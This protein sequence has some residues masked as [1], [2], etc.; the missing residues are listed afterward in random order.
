M[1]SID[2]QSEQGSTVLS[3]EERLTI[4]KST[5]ETMSEDTRLRVLAT[6]DIS[7]LVDA[8]RNTEGGTFDSAL[9][10]YF[11]ANP[12]E[13]VIECL[14]LQAYRPSSRH[15]M[16]QA[17]EALG[18][19]HTPEVTDFLT[20]KLREKEIYDSRGG[21]FG[22][23]ELAINRALEI[24]KA[25]AKHEGEKVTD[26]LIYASKCDHTE[27]LQ[28]RNQGYQVREDGKC[29]SYARQNCVKLRICA[30]EELGR[31]QVKDEETEREI[32]QALYDAAVEAQAEIVESNEASFNQGVQ[33][34]P[35]YSA[36]SSSKKPDYGMLFDTIIKAL[37]KRRSPESIEY[38]K[39]IALNE[40]QEDAPFPGSPVLSKDFA[41][42]AAEILVEL[43]K[44]R[45][46]EFLKGAL[47]ALIEN[48]NNN[49]IVLLGDQK[50][51][52]KCLDFL[53]ELIGCGDEN[54]RK[55]CIRRLKATEQGKLKLAGLL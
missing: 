10:E 25:T 51:S 38:L 15:R 27:H 13:D 3:D 16:K 48:G 46:D 54:I 45:D 34:Y 23:P 5:I 7:L 14:A 1:D 53:V 2:T 19:I 30:C 50:H 42:Q 40:P 18:Q 17:C 9:I 24:C 20:R 35:E 21:G 33:H 44:F 8:Y 26:A 4:F 41:Q 32:T 52:D 49:V 43:F 37:K 28:V 55:A 6:F 39:K 29:A 22:N 47:V 31:F 36:P 12:T 11:I